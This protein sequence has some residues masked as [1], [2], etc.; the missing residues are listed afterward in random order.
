MYIYIYI[1]ILQYVYIYITHQ[2]MYIHIIPVT[3]RVIQRNVKDGNLLSFNPNDLMM[4]LRLKQ[5]YMK[6]HPHSSI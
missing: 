5:I 4:A 3:Q 6:F 2:H 1:Y